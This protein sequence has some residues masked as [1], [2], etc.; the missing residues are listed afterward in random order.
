M[1]WGSVCGEHARPSMLFE[2]CCVY[3]SESVCSNVYTQYRQQGCC[4]HLSSQVLTRFKSLKQHH[5]KALSWRDTAAERRCTIWYKSE[6][7]LAVPLCWPLRLTPILYPAYIG[8]CFAVVDKRI[9]FLLKE[10][11]H[12][13]F[14]TFLVFTSFGELIMPALFQLL[15]R[16]IMHM[17]YSSQMYR[18]VWKWTLV[19]KQSFSA[20]EFTKLLNN[21]TLTHFG[22]AVWA[23]SGSA[24]FDFSVYVCTSVWG[25]VTHCASLHFVPCF[26]S[27]QQ[28]H[29][30]SFAL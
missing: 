25:G 19:K 24:A 20:N 29:L 30:F 17:W 11:I 1:T 21:Y 5:N 12:I 23:F 14:S 27:C 18:A 26:R 2:R 6:V 8:C 15:S 13:L 7:I 10:I 3:F 22:T 9:S 4:S 28:N 16:C